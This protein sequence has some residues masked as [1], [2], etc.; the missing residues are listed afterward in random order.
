[1]SS[2]GVALTARAFHHRSAPVDAHDRHDGSGCRGHKSLTRRLASSTVNGRSTSGDAFPREQI[3][4]RRPRHARQDLMSIRPRES[5]PLPST[6]QA[7]LEAP[8]VTKPSRSTNQASR[9]PAARAASLAS[10]GRQQHHRLDIAAAPAH[11][12]HRLDSDAGCRPAPRAWPYRPGA[13][14]RRASARHQRRGT[15]KSRGAAPR[16]TCR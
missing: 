1:M 11:I 16:E 4:Q 10:A 2:A 8:S 7:L 15:A 12:R 9:A 5:W 13:P 6:I 14:G 3:D